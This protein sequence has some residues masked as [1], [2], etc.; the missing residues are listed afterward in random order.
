MQNL[1]D[2]VENNINFESFK[3]NKTFYSIDLK[4]FRNF[5]EKC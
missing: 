5:E 2:F 3:E 1:I 4:N